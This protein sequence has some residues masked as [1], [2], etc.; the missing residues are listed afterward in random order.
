MR[1]YMRLTR[2]ESTHLKT[3]NSQVCPDLAA[4]NES[5]PSW[6]LLWKRWKISTLF[7]LKAS[8][9]TFL[10]FTLYLELDKSSHLHANEVYIPCV[11]IWTHMVRNVLMCPPLSNTKKYIFLKLWPPKVTHHSSNY[12]EYA[13]P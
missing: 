13:A 1:T 4:A 11:H 9:K 12:L 6:D 7:S 3:R 8:L 2:K 5:R 10:R